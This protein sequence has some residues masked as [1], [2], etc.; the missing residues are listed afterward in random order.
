MH[1]NWEE[2]QP[3]VDPPTRPCDAVEGEVVREAEGADETEA[4]VLCAGGAAADDDGAVDDVSSAA[5]EDLRG[6][7]SG[8]RGLGQPDR[9]HQARVLD[10][11]VCLGE[12]LQFDWGG[13]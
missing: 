6:L 5:G 4:L 11:F 10:Q 12:D 9:L 8:A 3:L 13:N 1:G 2:V 7:H